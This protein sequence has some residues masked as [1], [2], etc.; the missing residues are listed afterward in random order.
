[1]NAATQCAEL[2]VRI[3]E[4]SADAS[5]FVTFACALAPEA[6]LLV[7]RAVRA[8]RQLGRRRNRTGSDT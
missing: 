1:M 7:R 2:A 6:A 8:A 4:N 3:F 5:D